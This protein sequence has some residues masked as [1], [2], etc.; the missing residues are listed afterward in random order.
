[1]TN[2][3]KLSSLFFATRRLMIIQRPFTTTYLLYKEKEVIEKPKFIKKIETK[4]EKLAKFE[5]NENIEIASVES[6]EDVTD[7]SLGWKAIDSK[8]K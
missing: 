2:I 7:Y 3:L 4:E 6:I 5:M 1:M 8:D